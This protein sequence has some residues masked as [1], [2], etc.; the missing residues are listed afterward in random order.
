MAILVAQ[1]VVSQP[2]MGKMQVVGLWWYIDQR[3]VHLGQGACIPVYIYIYILGSDVPNFQ[4]I[5]LVHVDI[6]MPIY[7]YITVVLLQA[8][9]SPSSTVCCAT[10]DTFTSSDTSAFLGSLR[11]CCTRLQNKAW[12]LVCAD[13]GGW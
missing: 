12:Q 2:C 9:S 13:K 7:I 1:T 5:S 10:A 6:R 3:V 8:V 4:C 11:Q